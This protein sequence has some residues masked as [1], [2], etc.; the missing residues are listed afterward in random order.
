M[1]WNTDFDVALYTLILP[2]RAREPVTK[3]LA[4]SKPYSFCIFKMSNAPI[5]QFLV[6]DEG[7][8]V[9]DEHNKCSTMNMYLVH[10]SENTVPMI[11]DQE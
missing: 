5:H 6:T 11:P 1:V 10:S 2:L 4:L 8:Y 3:M 9:V 7:D